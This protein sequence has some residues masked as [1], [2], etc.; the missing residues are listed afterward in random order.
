MR[1]IIIAAV[2]V[3]LFITGYTVLSLLNEPY[4]ID[5]ISLNEAIRAAAEAEDQIEIL[6]LFNETMSREAEAMESD[7]RKR[8]ETLTILFFVFAGI[9]LLMAL[10]VY[11][12]LKFTLLHPFKKLEFFAL[13][14]A[15]GDLDYPLEMDKK[16]RFGAFSESF[17]LMREQLAAARESER[18]ANI[19]KKELVASL[20]HDV[21]TPVSSIKVVAEL[22]QAK[23]GAVPEMESIIRKADQID[24]LISNMFNATLE[25]LTQLK[26]TVGEI[27]SFDLADYIRSSDYLGKIK[28][29]SLPECV[30]NADS[31]RIRQ[32]I[33]NII[34]N[35]YKYADTEIEVAGRFDGEFLELS[36]RDFGPGVPPNESTLL[37][38]KFYRAKNAEGIAG[39]GLG[40]YLSRYF[41]IE[42][43][44]SLTVENDG[45]LIII[46]KLKI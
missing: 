28:P 26:V 45:G 10:S 40:L 41:I 19:S 22:Y 44:G 9:V 3:L 29:F 8:S 17:D 15:H 4:K 42:M 34:G 33:D 13:K 43:G 27:T 39:A 11:L 18:L 46:I 16:N 32:V 2:C 25:E 31:L 21:K 30:V 38:E 7:Y 23:H 14:V 35:S 24:L 36:I 6:R 1:K 12:Y 37:C 5:V 20:S